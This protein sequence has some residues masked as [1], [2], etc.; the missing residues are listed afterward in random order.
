MSKYVIEHEGFDGYIEDVVGGI[1]GINPEDVDKDVLTFSSY[2]AA[3]EMYDNIR[4]SLKGWDIAKE[5]ST[6]VLTWGEAFMCLS[7]V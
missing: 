3:K 2:N 5:T 4:A 6:S 7:R 1:L